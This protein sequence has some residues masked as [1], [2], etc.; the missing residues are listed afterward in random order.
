MKNYPSI[1]SINDNIKWLNS[2]K[3][4]ARK[5]ISSY[6]ERI[7]RLT[8][9]IKEIQELNEKGYSVIDSVI[10]SNEIPKN[11]KISLLLQ[12]KHED[13]CTG[14]SAGFYVRASWLLDNSQKRISYTPINIANAYYKWN[15]QKRKSEITIKLLDYTQIDLPENVKKQ[16]V[17]YVDKNYHKLLK[18]WEDNNYF[19]SIDEASYKYDELSS[20]LNFK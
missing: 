20:L 9:E 14:I 1:S 12:Y 3:E 7:E 8:K 13:K 15:S 17:K 16:F 11:K 2:K 5:I 4:N 6:E 10:F 19:I 18:R